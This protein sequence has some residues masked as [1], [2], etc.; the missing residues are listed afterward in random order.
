MA[1]RPLGRVYSI[2]YESQTIAVRDAGG[3]TRA[4]PLSRL[5]RHGLAALFLNETTQLRKWFPTQLGDGWSHQRAAEAL[6]IACGKLGFVPH[7]ERK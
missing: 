1:V 7:P 6:I 3:I 5:G 2:A 4:V